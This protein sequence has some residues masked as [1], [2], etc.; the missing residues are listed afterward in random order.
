MPTGWRTCG[1]CGWWQRSAGPC[2]GCGSLSRSTRSQ[3]PA[4]APPVLGPPSDDLLKRRWAEAKASASNARHVKIERMCTHCFLRTINAKPACRGCQ[5]NLAD[6]AR[7]LPGQWPPLACPS[8]LLK[9]YE[10]GSAPPPDE[11]CDKMAP[12]P[13]ANEKNDVMEVDG[14][15]GGDRPLVQIPAAQLKSEISRLEKHL[16]EMPADGFQALRDITEQSLMT[17]KRELQARKPEGASLD[18]AIAR[19]R[20]AAKAKQLAEEQVKDCQ[21][22]LDRADKALQ[23]ANEADQVATQ[24][25][26][27]MRALIADSEHS[28]EQRPIATPAIGK[29]TAQNLCTFLQHAGLTSEQ[30][31]HVNNLLGQQL[32]AVPPPP[33]P[34]PPA[35]RTPGLATQLLSPDGKPLRHPQ[36]ADNA[37]RQGRS[38]VARRKLPPRGGAADYASTHRD[39]SRDASRTPDRGRHDSRASSPVVEAQHARELSPTLPMGALQPLA[40]GHPLPTS[41][42]GVAPAVVGSKGAACS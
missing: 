23:L 38:P 13:P 32:P 34:V 5:R 17:A 6:C 2:A 30:L 37:A 42:D 24:E 14:Q 25:V 4:A 16:L 28:A 35:D 11:T 33:P 7:I 31:L 21:A 20:Q 29:Q 1:R 15:Q 9:R 12:A 39:D 22:A 40:A 27:K 41:L 3:Q 18:K 8:H 36:A 19:Q 26:Q 10:E